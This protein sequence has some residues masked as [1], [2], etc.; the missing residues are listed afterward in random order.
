MRPEGA[1]LSKA[2]G[3]ALGTSQSSILPALKGRLVP[4]VALGEDEMD[5]Q[6]CE[7]LGMAW[8]ALSGLGTWGRLFPR[9][10]PWAGI[11]MRL[12]RAEE[13]ASAHPGAGASVSCLPEREKSK[14]MQAIRTCSPAVRL[15]QCGSLP[16]EIM[17]LHFSAG[18]YSPRL[19]PALQERGLVVEHGCLAGRLPGRLGHGSE[20]R[21]SP[22]SRQR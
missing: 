7:R 17:R 9:A 3:N 5:V 8:D 15:C 16:S 10:L 12:W 21:E 19:D 4:H 22:E 18:A 11:E 14:G 2:Q 1:K 20:Y 13:R 6:A